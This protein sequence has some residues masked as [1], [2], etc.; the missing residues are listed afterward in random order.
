MEFISSR[1][2]TLLTTKVH[3]PNSCIQQIIHLIAQTITIHLITPS[4]ITSQRAPVRSPLEIEL[5]T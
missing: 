5:A 3:V 2:L 4:V 1:Y